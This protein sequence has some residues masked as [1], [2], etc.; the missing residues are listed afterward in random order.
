MAD[1][2]VVLGLL[3][4]GAVLLSDQGAGGPGGILPHV[5][6]ITVSGL[7]TDDRKMSELIDKVAGADQVKA[8]I[9]DHQQPG[10]HHHRR[11]SH[12]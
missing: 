2:A 10:R 7:I 3:L 1:A 5:A 11:R 12:V 6:R 9:L 4:F 8:V